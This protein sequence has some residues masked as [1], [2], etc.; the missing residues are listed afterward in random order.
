MTSFRDPEFRTRR[1]GG[2]LD[3]DYVERSE[4]Y[5]NEA[6]GALAKALS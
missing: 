3:D 6:L 2:R 1:L 4:E 5:A